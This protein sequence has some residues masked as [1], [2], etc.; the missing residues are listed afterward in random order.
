[1]QGIWTSPPMGSQVR[2]RQCSIAISAAFSTCCGVP[3]RISA[4]AP[5]AIDAAEPD[6]ALAPDFGAGD[7]GLL[8]VQR[9]DRSGGQ[10]KSHRDAVG[11][12]LVLRGVV[13]GVVQYR[14]D[15]AGRAVGGRGDDASAGGVLLVDGQGDEVDPILGELRFPCGGL[16]R[17]VARCH[18][19]ARR[20]TCSATGQITG[21]RHAVGGALVHDVAQM[22]QLFGDVF[23]LVAMPSRERASPR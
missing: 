1:M 5:A 9:S 11:I 19:C 16:R 22:Q 17:P 23:V 7:G 15:D 4:S 12:G 13:L 6:F 2:P 10:Q 14:R 18:W 20:R 3:P 21:A 8:F